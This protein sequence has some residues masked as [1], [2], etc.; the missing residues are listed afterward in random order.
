MPGQC[1]TRCFTGI[2]L[3]TDYYGYD[4]A[5]SMLIKAVMT[6]HWLSWMKDDSARQSTSFDEF[7]S[8]LAHG[9]TLTYKIWGNDE[10]SDSVLPKTIEVD[11]S[12]PVT[13]VLSRRVK[14]IKSQFPDPVSGV[15]GSGVWFVVGSDGGLILEQT[16]PPNMIHDDEYKAGKLVVS[17]QA[18]LCVS[19]AL[20]RLSLPLS[21]QV[22]GKEVPD[23]PNE[24]VDKIVRGVRPLVLVV[25][26]P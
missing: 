2:G 23:A 4:T 13:I 24:K 15:W 26:K 3:N 6:A 1:I 21:R 25:W 18:S 5:V 12:K 10:T 14:G 9:E 20:S 8:K 22:A 7:M 19:Y 16:F 17:G 11:P